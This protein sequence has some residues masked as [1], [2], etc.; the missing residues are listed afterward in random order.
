MLARAA[1]ISGDGANP[2]SELWRLAKASV[3]RV[4]D[5]AS[6]S[7]TGLI[8][9][10]TAQ[11]PSLGQLVNDRSSLRLIDES[12]ITHSLSRS[13]IAP[14]LKPSLSPQRHYRINS[15]R[16]PLRDPTGHKCDDYQ[17]QHERRKGEWP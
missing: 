12:R 8:V 14:L 1:C 4:S 10:I 3:I 2:L 13:V 9:V 6:V 17:Q 7:P 15:C 11:F 5:R 16:S